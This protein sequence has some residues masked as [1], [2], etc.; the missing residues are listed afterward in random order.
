MTLN[1]A[2]NRQAY[3]FAA[4][5]RAP[6]M[7]GRTFCMF[8]HTRL[9]D[10]WPERLTRGQSDRWDLHSAIGADRSVLTRA[11]CVLKR[12]YWLV[13]AL[14]NGRGVDDLLAIFRQRLGLPPAL[15]V[16]RS[17]PQPAAY[18]PTRKKK[19]KARAAAAHTNACS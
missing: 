14:G 12:R 7:D 16:R 18:C 15:L 3:Y 9:A 8:S 1:P 4:D 19:K 11:W 17:V 10:A 13:G 2:H 5:V 6:R